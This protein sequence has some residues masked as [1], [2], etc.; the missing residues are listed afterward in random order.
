MILTPK[1]WSEFQHY[2]NRSPAWIKLHRGLLDNF[3]FHRLPTASRALA[4]MLWLLASEFEDGKI[5]ASLDEL[6]FRLRMTRGELA[7][8][9]SPLVD[10]GFFDASEALAECKQSAFLEKE[11]EEEEERDSEPKG[12]GADAPDHR[13][14]LFG[15]GLKK[16]ASIT[17]KGPDACRSYVGR[18]LKLAGDDAVIVL[19]LIEDA[20][21][22]RVIDPSGWILA[23]L[24]QTGPPK[25]QLTE[26]QQRRRETQE[27]LNDLQNYAS[28]GRSPENPRLLPGNSGE[29]PEGLRGGAG[30]AVIDLSPSGRVSGG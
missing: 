11:R 13:K 4:P 18:C 20:E 17:G 21:R 24:Q 9:L 30:G 23:R 12:S 7:D 15:D 3:D 28:G 22:N 26:S 6:A 16:L 19:G 27:I 8:A 14:R 10:S 29:R 5:T 1:N 25:R 2:S